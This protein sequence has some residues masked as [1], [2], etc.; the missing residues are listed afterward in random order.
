MPFKVVS[1]KLCCEGIM[2]LSYVSTL[3]RTIQF[4]E[5]V[6]ISHYEVCILNT[7]NLKSQ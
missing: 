2:L 5:P 7:F 6:S 1:Q 4:K 3:A